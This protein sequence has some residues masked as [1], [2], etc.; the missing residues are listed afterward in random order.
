MLKHKDKSF[1]M[2]MLH[3]CTDQ[4]AHQILT[5]R[6]IFFYLDLDVPNLIYK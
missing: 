6:K 4:Q 5:N 3:K 1:K 2:F